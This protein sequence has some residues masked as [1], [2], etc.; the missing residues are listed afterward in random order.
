MSAGTA[1]QAALVSS[2]QQIDGLT[3]VY[4]GPPARASYPYL[5][6]D[7]G[8]EIDWG[9][10]SAAGREIGLA[11][12]LWDELPMRL[13][14]LA[15]QVEQCVESLST[16]EDWEVVSIRFNRRR[17]IRDIAGPW[18]VALDFRARLLQSA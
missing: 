1:L 2:L 14:D 17:V 12:T 5:V 16:A 13:Q 11:V 9:H 4:D 6:V 7:A 18:A 8:T 15:D 10:K 3:G